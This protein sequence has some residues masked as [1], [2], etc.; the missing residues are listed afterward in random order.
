MTKPLPPETLATVDAPE[1][2]SVLFESAGLVVKLVV[3]RADGAPLTDADRDVVPVLVDGYA[4]GR[5][6]NPTDDELAQVAAE[7][8]RG[9]RPLGRTGTGGE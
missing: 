4:L 6:V 7:A 3:T 9:K 5:E 8:A 2:L 1:D